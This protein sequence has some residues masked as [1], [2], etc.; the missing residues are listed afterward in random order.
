MLAADMI[1]GRSNIAMPHLRAWR[2]WAGL[3]QDELGARAGATGITVWHAEKASSRVRRGT[4][5]RLATALGVPVDVLTRCAPADAE[6]ERWAREVAVTFARERMSRQGRP[7][8]A[9]RIGR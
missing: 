1:G 2:L 5:R 4:A 3:T 9:G 8:Y 6:A 7:R